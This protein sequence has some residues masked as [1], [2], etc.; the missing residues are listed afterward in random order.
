M[1]NLKTRIARSV[2]F[3][4][5]LHVACPYSPWP[6]KFTCPTGHVVLPGPG[7]RTLNGY[8][9][10]FT[11]ACNEY[12]VDTVV[13]LDELI[14]GNNRKEYGAD[15]MVV[16]LNLQIEAAEKVLYPVVK[17]RKFFAVSGSP[18]H[19]S[20]D[21]KSSKAIVEHF[22]GQFLGMLANLSFNGVIVNVAHG[23]GGGLTYSSTKGDKEIL[24][25]E[26][27][28]AKGRLP[29]IQLMV[30]GHLHHFKYVESSDMAYLFLPGWTDW[31]PYKPSLGLYGRQPD[32]GW[33]IMLITDKG[34]IRFVKKIYPPPNIAQ[35]ERAA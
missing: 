17:G 28:K 27:S 10:D 25:V 30:R 13:S 35:M 22:G 34:E 20:L 4:S 23:V 7:Q 1:F 29:N 14:D 8:W 2:A 6:D 9:K 3:V 11:K 16:D 24:W 21:T 31:I 15:R 33:V 18:Y 12:S 19:D 26:S 5:D 32:I